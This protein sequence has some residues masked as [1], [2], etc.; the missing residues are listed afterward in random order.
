MKK[1]RA[2]VKMKIQTYSIKDWNKINDQLFRWLDPDKC[3]QLTGQSK[4]AQ[5]LKDEYG[6]ALGIYF[7]F[8][9]HPYYIT[10]KEAAS[11]YFKDAIFSLKNGKLAFLFTIDSELYV[12]KA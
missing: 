1:K 7:D 9:H 11:G 2:R 12:C 3:T 4:F 10:L 5:I 8:S 6:D